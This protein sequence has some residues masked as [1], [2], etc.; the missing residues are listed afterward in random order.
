MTTQSERLAALE[1]RLGDHEARCEERLA[2]IRATAASTLRAVE[3]LKGRAWGIAAA[4]LA[5]ALAQVWS[6]NTSRMER[7]ESE[8]PALEQGAVDVAA[9]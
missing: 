1:Q 3:G 2:E 5:W 9:R 6:V 4:L 7:L 8:R